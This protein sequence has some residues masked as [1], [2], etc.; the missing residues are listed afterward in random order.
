MTIDKT[1]ALTNDILRVDSHTDVYKVNL[2]EEK[3]SILSL[4]EHYNA[5]TARQ[6]ERLDAINQDLLKLTNFKETK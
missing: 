6:T 2:E 3:E 5:D 4:L 1:T